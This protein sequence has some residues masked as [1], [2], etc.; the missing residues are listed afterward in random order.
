MLL[1]FVYKAFKKQTVEEYAVVQLS[2][3]LSDTLAH[4][5]NC[6][7]I[8]STPGGIDII[9]ELVHLVAD[10]ASLMDESM[11]GSRLLRAAKS[12]VSETVHKRTDKCARQLKRLRYKLQTAFEASTHNDLAEMKAGIKYI[13]GKV[14]APAPLTFN[15]GSLPP[16]PNHPPQSVPPPLATP[17]S[18]L[19][20]PPPFPTS[21]LPPLPPS[22][23][24]FYPH[25]LIDGMPTP[26]S[27]YPPPRRTSAAFP[28]PP[29]PRPTLPMPSVGGHYGQVLPEAQY[30]AEPD[31]IVY[32]VGRPSE[33]YVQNT[34]RARA[35]T[36]Q[37]LWEP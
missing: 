13:R 26:H 17:D 33:E 6:R 12:I 20:S 18:P 8:I 16:R 4:A 15:T 10:C 23:T 9:R 29:G 34:A 5:R 1:S 28:S 21:R 11:N 25:S 3:D 27:P 37:L 22:R 7:D 19:N 35:A 30:V 36:H 14:S 24:T 32:P 2:L 31:D